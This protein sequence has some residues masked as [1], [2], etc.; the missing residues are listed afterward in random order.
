MPL[1]NYTHQALLNSLFGKTSNFGTLSAV[2]T[3]YV[4]LSSTT[5]TM[6]G[7]NVTEPS[8][9]SYARV[10]TAGSDWD[11]ATD[12]DPSV[13]DNVAA[14]TF[15]EATGDWVSAAD[16]THFVLYDGDSPTNFL[17]FGALT[18]AKPVISGD[19]ASFPIG[20]LVNQ[21]KSPA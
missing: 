19:T 2:P 7:A 20:D 11:S 21:L 5:P 18:V 8:S 15:P 6:A 14:I 16:L 3:I 12:A 17:G 9:G 13:L 4:G 1:S 10:E